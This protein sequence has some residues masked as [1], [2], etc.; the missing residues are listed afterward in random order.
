MDMGNNQHINAENDRVNGF[1]SNCSSPLLHRK[2]GRFSFY[3]QSSETSKKSSK[4]GFLR[5]FKWFKKRRKSGDSTDNESTITNS[6]V[7]SLNSSLNDSVFF[8]LARSKSADNQQPIGRSVKR[9]D[10][11]KSNQAIAFNSKSYCSFIEDKSL[12][13]DSNLP[14]DDKYIN[15]SSSEVQKKRVA[16]SPPS[17][18]TEYADVVFRDKS[19]LTSKSEQRRSSALDPSNPF[20][21]SKRYSIESTCSSKGSETYART[22]RRAPQPPVTSWTAKVQQVSQCQENIQQTSVVA[23][24]T[25]PSA[26]ERPISEILMPDSSEASLLSTLRS[27]SSRGSSTLKGSTS[28]KCSGESLRLE[29]GILRQDLPL[30]ASNIAKKQP[31][32]TSTPKPWYKR[33]KKGKSKAVEKIDASDKIYEFWRPEIQFDGKDIVLNKKEKGATLPQS[34]KSNLKK[35]ISDMCKP[36]RR[37]QVS[38]LANISQ[39]DQEAVEQLRK[40]M[41]DMKASKAAYD[42]AFYKQPEPLILTQTVISKTSPSIPEKLPHLTKDEDTTNDYDNVDTLKTDD[43]AKII[44]NFVKLELAKETI[45]KEQ[46][47]ESTGLKSDTNRN[48]NLNSWPMKNFGSSDVN[49]SA[50]YEEISKSAFTPAP[51]AAKEIKSSTSLLQMANLDAE[52]FYQLA[53]DVKRSP[54]SRIKSQGPNPSLQDEFISS[55]RQISNAARLNRSPKNFGLRMNQMFSPDVSVIMEGSESMTSSATTPADDDL[56]SIT[57]RDASDTIYNDFLFSS[58]GITDQQCDKTIANEIMLELNEV[59]FEIDRIN[60]EENEDQRQK[61]INKAEKIRNEVRMLRTQN[62]FSVWEELITG[63]VAKSNNDAGPPPPPIDIITAKPES[64]L[65]WVCDVCTL[66]NLSWKITCEACSSRRPSKPTRMKDDGTLVPAPNSSIEN[67]GTDATES[68]EKTPQSNDN[69]SKING[70]STA[71]NNDN[72]ADKNKNWGLKMKKYFEFESTQNNTEGLNSEIE[73]ELQAHILYNKIDSDPQYGKINMVG[74]NKKTKD[75]DHSENIQDVSNYNVEE[76]RAARLK[77]FYLDSASVE[78]LHDQSEDIIHEAEAKVSSLIPQFNGQEK[79]FYKKEP[80]RRPV[81][82]V[83]GAV[84]NRISIFN[85]Q[86]QSDQKRNKL[87]SRR[88][89]GLVK[90]QGSYFEKMQ[91]DN[92]NCNRSQNFIKE[93][94]KATDNFSNRN[95]AT[96]ISKFDDIA[97]KAELENLHPRKERLITKKK[98]KPLIA[99]QKPHIQKT[100]LT[101]DQSTVETIQTKNKTDAIIDNQQRVQQASVSCIESE[102]SVQS[103]EPII[104]D[105]V[106][107][108][109]SEG[110]RNR[111]SMSSSVFELIHENEFEQI[112]AE[113]S[114]RGSPTPTSIYEDAHEYDNGNAD[115]IDNFEDAMF[116]QGSYYGSCINDFPQASIENKASIPSLNSRTQDNEKDLSLYGDKLLE[117]ELE[118][119]SQQLTL[120]KGQSSFTGKS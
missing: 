1:D 25:Q 30:D 77:K 94:P 83:H 85:Q 29:N 22:K 16:P 13:C 100:E 33:K 7:S 75:T 50:A 34:E 101:V 39:L 102:V 96:A 56:N 113:H 52:L 48:D 68:S 23:S 74:N 79:T 82:N 119:F 104:L 84:K 107:Y 105:G 24:S 35:K 17:K 91:N 66:I 76:L 40:D 109:A 65:K 110:E 38:L 12:D 5:I 49:T 14:I 15:L 87:Q 54:D 37:S 88:S 11:A 78:E 10:T 64:K 41:D 116:D 47:I 42:N 71:I 69:S 43:E 95:I 67:G 115:V 73:R 55:S 20:Y 4:K 62:N 112:E 2:R 59:K 32:N 8:P 3:S 27:N 61:D 51:S 80:R 45:N 103:D 108:T 21:V 9:T 57:T 118:R 63:S 114:Q 26:S 31:A 89:I 19:K 97:A 58:S 86:V 98:M 81:V 92:N 70:S 90:E 120:P 106:L 53:K 28:S 93:I 72:F 18:S 99:N 117:Q 44:K 46:N 6:S 111:N 36:K 60:Y